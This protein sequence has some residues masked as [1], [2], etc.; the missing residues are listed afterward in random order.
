MSSN[1][2]SLFKTNTNLEADGVWFS[3]GNGVEFCIRRFGGSNSQKVKL[4]MTKFYKPHARLIELDQLPIKDTAL[5]SAKIFAEAC[6]VDWKGV[7]IDGKEEAYSFDKAVKLFTDLPE[8]FAVLQKYSE[9]FDS[10]KE[11]L[12]NS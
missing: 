12:G 5:I 8:L 6:V 11:D 9:G 10:F 7:E 4:A 3:I 1:L 2:H